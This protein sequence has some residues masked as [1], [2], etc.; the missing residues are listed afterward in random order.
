MLPTHAIHT[1]ASRSTFNEPVGFG[2]YV[3]N[4]A[5]LDDRLFFYSTAN[6]ATI[7]ASAF[8]VS[9]ST[10]TVSMVANNFKDTY[11]YGSGANDFLA[12]NGSTM[13]ELFTSWSAYSYINSPGMI[14]YYDRFS[15]VT[16]N[17]ANGTGDA[18][19][20]YDSRGNDTYT[21]SPGRA[22]LSGSGFRNIAVGFSRVYAYQTG[23]VDVAN[24]TGSADNDRI[25]GNSSWTSVS[26]TG[27][28]Q[29]VFAFSVV[30]VN[31][32]TN[33]IDTVDLTDSSGNDSLTATRDSLELRFAS[34]KRITVAAI[35]RVTARGTNGG[36]NR[37]TVA[38]SLA[39][40][41]AFTGSWR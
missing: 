29:Q 18:A 40:V 38:N 28:L 6:G 10:A 21:G 34:G 33:G 3:A 22:E 20:M 9:H 39:Y 13:T 7:T 32:G 11:V 16:V 26:S 41:L 19:I 4:G 35:D 31:G 15:Q 1:N 17:S 2:Q 37:K 30:N 25:F 5:G 14:R 36:I 27:F 12:Y 8:Q 23:G 24:I